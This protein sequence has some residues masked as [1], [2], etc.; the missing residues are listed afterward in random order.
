VERFFE[1]QAAVASEPDAVLRN[2]ERS[3][4]ANEHARLETAG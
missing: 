1:R 4:D 3:D 2:E